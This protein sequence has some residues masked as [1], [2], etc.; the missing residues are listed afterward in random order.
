MVLAGLQV[1]YNTVVWFVV[2]S[3][4]ELQGD[5]KFQF[6]TSVNPWLKFSLRQLS[7]RY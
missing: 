7:I 2:K 3:I 5:A 4:S 6:Q 1:F